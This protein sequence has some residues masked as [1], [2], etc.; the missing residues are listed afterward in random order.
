LSELELSI[1]EAKF[2]LD[3]EGRPHVGVSFE[4][5]MTLDEYKAFVAGQSGNVIKRPSSSLLTNG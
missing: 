3:E 2:L 1:V 5:V 4:A